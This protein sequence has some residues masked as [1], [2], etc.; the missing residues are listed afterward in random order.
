MGNLLETKYN[1]PCY[2]KEC[3]ERA[4]DMHHITYSSWTN[5]AVPLCAWHHAEIT[6]V[7]AGFLDGDLPCQESNF[8]VRCR[9]FDA[10]LVRFEKWIQGQLVPNIEHVT[11]LFRARVVEPYSK[12][13]AKAG[14]WGH[15]GDQGK[16]PK[17]ILIRGGNKKS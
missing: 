11:S 1:L 14:D 15:G 16:R 5:L 8:L 13:R 12:K 10:R 17:E 4:A 9:G 3:P 7:N 2:V 6:A